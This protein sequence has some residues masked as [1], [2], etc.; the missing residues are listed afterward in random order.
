MKEKNGQALKLHK[1]KL[2]PIKQKIIALFEHF[3]VLQTPYYDR[4]G[5]NNENYIKK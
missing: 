3:L 4:N 2:V 5:F 1:K